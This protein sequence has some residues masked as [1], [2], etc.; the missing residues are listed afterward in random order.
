L[1]DGP[2]RRAGSPA[3]ARSDSS[4]SDS[5][6]PAAGLVAGS[7]ALSDGCMARKSL[8]MHQQRLEAKD[9]VQRELRAWADD[10]LRTRCT[11]FWLKAP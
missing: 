10:V 5:D 7:S 2:G 1:R 6:A 8:A 3:G 11:R 9:A 4:D